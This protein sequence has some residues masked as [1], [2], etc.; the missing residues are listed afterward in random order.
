M[1]RE[2][3]TARQAEILK[4]LDTLK[5]LAVND[6][7]IADEAAAAQSD[8]VSAEAD[9][10]EQNDAAVTG[11]GGTDVDADLASKADAITKA[12][13]EVVTQSL[14]TGWT[15]KDEGDQNAKANANWP[16]TDAERQQV[17]NS[18]LKLAKE[19]LS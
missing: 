13:H 19:L 6:A 7:D 14:T 9:A 8:E 17:A 11:E 4:A 16:L 3:L 18:L 12:E 10:I 2:R 1:S 5:K 15:P